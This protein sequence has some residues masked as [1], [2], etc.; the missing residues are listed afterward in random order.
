MYTYFVCMYLHLYRRAHEV[1]I[2]ASARPRHNHFQPHHARSEAYIF[3]RN[4]HVRISTG[5]IYSFLQM[6]WTNAYA[7]MHTR[8][9]MQICTRRRTYQLMWDV[10]IYMVLKFVQI[11]NVMQNKYEE[12]HFWRLYLHM[13]TSFLAHAEYM[14][15]CTVRW[16]KIYIYIY[17]ACEACAIWFLYLCNYERFH[18]KWTSRNPRKQILI[19]LVSRSTKAD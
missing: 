18:T 14:H 7:H 19:F 15:W 9:H 1:P 12:Y 2:Q 8:L 17:M 4:E 6:C 10:F 13:P 11:H 3:E 16:A 5:A